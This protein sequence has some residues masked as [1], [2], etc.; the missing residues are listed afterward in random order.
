MFIDGTYE[1]DV[2]GLAGMSYAVGRESASIYNES[3]AGRV[4]YSSGNQVHEHTN[5]FYDNGTLLPL[6]IQGNTGPVGSGDKQVQAY[7]FRLCVTQNTSNMAPFPV[8][9]TYDPSDWELF[10][11][12]A[13]VLGSA[14]TLSDFLGN[15][16]AA[17]NGKF[18]MNNGGPTST[19]CIGCSWGWPEASWTARR[20]IWQLHFDYQAGLLH[21]LQVRCVGLVGLLVGVIM[22]NE[23]LKLH[24]RTQHSRQSYDPTPTPGAF[25]MTNSPTP[26]TGPNSCMCERAVGSWA[27][28]CLCKRMRSKFATSRT[29]SHADPTIS[30]RT[31][32]SEWCALPIQSTV[33]RRVEYRRMAM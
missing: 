9:S 11:R 10:R 27:I 25:A 12:R 26:I 29:P 6:F 20:A 32:R 15:T 30:T 4:S 28:G 1:G 16:R 8:P 19:D 7:N 14:V 21:F 2:F 23:R 24:R 31:T 13:A 33:S 3:L 22:T 17:V 18:D 5:P